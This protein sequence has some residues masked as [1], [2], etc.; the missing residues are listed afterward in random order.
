MSK[1]SNLWAQPKSK[2]LLGIPVGA[3]LAL[4]MGVVGTV[5]FNTVIHAT[6]S[7]AFCTNCHVPGY[8]A[9]EFQLSVHGTNATGY[10]VACADCHVPKDFMG[11]MWRKITAMREV[12]WQ[13]QG[14]YNTPEGYQAHKKEMQKNIIEGFRANDSKAC[15]NCHDVNQMNF[16]KQKKMAA[17]MHQRM[18][19]M[20]KTCIDCHKGKIAHKKAK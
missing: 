17:K 14:D 20:K 16:K 12:Y 4:V 9:E 5:G 13:V 6:S 10:K 7:E 15:R 3:F 1:Q 11:K 8:A 2:W 18:D 19:K